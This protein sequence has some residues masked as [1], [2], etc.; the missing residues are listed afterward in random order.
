MVGF[1]LRLP[2]SASPDSLISSHSQFK[3][4]Q[5]KDRIASLPPVYRQ[6]LNASDRSILSKPIAELVQ[7]VHKQVLSPLD[8]LRTYGKVAV[9]AHEKTN[10]VTEVML[11]EAE[12]WAEKEVNLMGPLAG[13]PVSL[14]DSIAVKGFDASV[15]TSCNVGKPYA[16]DG[17]MVRI[18]KDAGMSLSHPVCIWANHS[19]GPYRMSRRRCPSPSY[20]LNRRT[21]CGANVLTPTILSTLPAARPVAKEPSSLWVDALVSDLTW[22]ALFALPPPGAVYIPCA[23]VQD[24]GRSWA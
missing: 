23:A 12:E 19:Q 10:C 6:A 20:P 9:K 1:P 16:A 24:A 5:R 2:F 8:V 13:I 17:A 22:L 15:G 3:Q 4:Q 21:L 14:K 18:L 11:P 7:D